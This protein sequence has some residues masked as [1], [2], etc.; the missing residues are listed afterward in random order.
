VSRPGSGIVVTVAV[1]HFIGG[2][3]GLLWDLC[4]VL[5]IVMLPQVRAMA[6][7]G[8]MLSLTVYLMDNAPGFFAAQ[9]T[10]TVSGLIFDVLLVVAGIGL[11]MGRSWGRYLSFGYGGLSLL[12]KLALIVHILVVVIPA[13][14]TYVAVEAPKIANPTVR[15]N[16]VAQANAS[17]I[18]FPVLYGALMIYPCVVLLLMLLPAAGRYFQPGRDDRDEDR[19]YDDRRRRRRDFDDEDRRRDSD[20]G[21]DR[22]GRSRID[23]SGQ[24]YREDEEDRGPRRR[25]GDEDEERPRRD[26]WGE[27]R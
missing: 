10:F 27:D 20:E 17:K 6:Q 2:G 22:G 21:D 12:V 24:I 1:L 3:L 11:L 8:D 25:W 23:R 15:T 26:R 5:D 14:N 4:R 18:M 13:L 9:A 19:D 7:P 16:A